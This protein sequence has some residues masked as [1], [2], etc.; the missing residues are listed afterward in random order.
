[1]AVN[2]ARSPTLPLPVAAPPERASRRVLDVGGA[3]ILLVLTL[4]L[5]L[6]GALLVLVGS[7][8]PVFFGHRRIG[9]GG[10]PFRCWKLR[11][12]TRG[13]ELW[14][15]LDPQLRERHSR[16][17]FKLRVRE[18]PRVTPVGRWLRR[19]H[20]DELPQLFNVIGGTMSLVGPRPVVEDELAHYGEAA[21]EFLG[22]RPGIFGAWTSR[23]RRRPPYPERARLELAYVR[24][25][26][27]GMDL[28]ILLR[29]VPV[30]LR[31]QED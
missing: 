1:M 23:G 15:A 3:V 30:V 6:L 25:R 19:T 29:S 7:G 17:G 12:M 2:L 22:T 27:A 24:S 31:G 9:M 5:L 20:I 11:T 18:D 8:R 16:N 13:A 10:R 26:S 4:P 14:L 28:R 21:A